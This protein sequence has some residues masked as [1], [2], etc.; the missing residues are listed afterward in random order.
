MIIQTLNRDYYMIQRLIHTKEMDIYLCREDNSHS[1]YRLIRLKQE[2]LI[3]AAISVFMD[4]KDNKANKEF[5]ECF[6]KENEFYVVF[7]HCENVTLKQKLESEQS[8]L[9]ERLEIGKNIIEKII[10]LNIPLFMQYEALQESNLCVASSLDIGFNFTLESIK[11][12]DSIDIYNVSKALAAVF[13]ICFAKELEMD[14]SEDINS[15]IEYLELGKYEN[16]FHIYQA[17]NVIYLRLKELYENGQIKPRGFWFRVWNRIKRIMKILK[18][19]I[20]AL[21][22]FLIVGY[23]IYIIM[24]KKEVNE[25]KTVFKNI[26]TVEIKEHIMEE[27]D[28][29]S[30]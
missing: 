24:Q 12:K 18:P 26:G 11:E 27:T 5:V 25:A 7:H 30:D 13:R 6:P 8:S 3:K 1:I 22:L 4:Q 10:L 19:I 9:V 29:P 15:F 21:V 14:A 17:Y 2:D 20:Y 23:L 16:Y 28:K